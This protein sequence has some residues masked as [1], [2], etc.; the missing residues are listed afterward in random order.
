[1]A[2][3]AT[4][5]WEV[6]TTG[7]DNNGG[8][9]N[10]AAAGTD[11]SLSDNPTVVIDN[12]TITCTTPGANSNT[13]T[14]TAGYTP[15]SADIGNVVQ[16][17][18]GGTNVNAGFYEITNVSAVAPP[19]GTWTLT[20]ATNLTTAS[21]AGS[22]ITGNMGGG[23][24]TIGKAAGVYVAGN[25][26]YIQAGTYTLSAT[27]TWSVAGTAAA[28]IKI[29]G[30]NSFHGDDGTPPVITRANNSATLFTLTGTG[31]VIFNN[32]KFTY[33]GASR[34][35]AFTCVTT[36][37]VVVGLRKIITDGCANGFNQG[38][39]APTVALIVEG[40]LFQNGSGKGI[41]A[42][43]HISVINSTIYNFT[44]NGIDGA[45]TNL[46]FVVVKSIIAKNAIGIADTATGRD[47]IIEV[48]GCTIVDNTSDG[49]KGAETTGVDTL[50]ITNTIFYNNSGK[51]V[52]MVTANA[53]AVGNRNNAYGANGTANAN[54]P[55]GTND[56]TLGADPF[57]SRSS[58]D[59][60][61]NNNTPGGAQC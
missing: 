38:G 29:I 46:G 53:V 40:S 42:D 21:G 37:P 44:G 22:A 56:V 16:I 19:N 54:F 7:N 57:T 39:R 4:Q 11:R 47:N 2:L 28:P 26:I 8:A 43:S 55:A 13:L 3:A 61:L 33:T 6:R 23:L 1:M 12:S 15:S 14:F 20:G 24:L 49:I 51:A 31:I 9:F 34:G 60:T 50:S 5:V 36:S 17:L 59:W 10:S 32:L 48:N 18:A 45:P 27:V 25:I 41:T 52:N 58:Q 30:Y 35:D